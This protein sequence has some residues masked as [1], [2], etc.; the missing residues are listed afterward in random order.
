MVLHF[1][2]ETLNRRTQRSACKSDGG[3]CVKLEVCLTFTIRNSVH[4]QYISKV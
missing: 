3:V 4:L 2:S 1:K